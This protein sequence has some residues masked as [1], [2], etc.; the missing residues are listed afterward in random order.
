MGINIH[1]DITRPQSRRF[2]PLRVAAVT[3]P[4]Q[5]VAAP[6]VKVVTDNVQL[7]ANSMI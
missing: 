5:Q 6:V 7:G 1:H 3:Q 2:A 4:V